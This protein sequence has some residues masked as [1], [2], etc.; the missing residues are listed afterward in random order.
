MPMDELLIAEGVQITGDRVLN[1]EEL[2]WD[3]MVECEIE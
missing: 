2:H 3:P 1:F